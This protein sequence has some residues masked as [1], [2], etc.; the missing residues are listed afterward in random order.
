MQRCGQVG[1][2]DSER[3]KAQPLRK[4]CQSITWIVIMKMTIIAITVVKIPL[5]LTLA[6]FLLMLTLTVLRARM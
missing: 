2:R 4:R 3:A 1:G 5:M 6:A